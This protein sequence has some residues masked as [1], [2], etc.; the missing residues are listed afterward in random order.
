V[1][2]AID[3]WRAAHPAIPA[4]QEAQFR[5]AKRTRYV[6]VPVMGT[7]HYFMGEV[8]PTICM[9]FPIQ[10]F[11]AWIMKQ[12][13]RAV[14]AAIDW[15]ET[16][17]IAQVHDALYLETS[18]PAA[19]WDLL[20]TEMSKPVMLDGRLLAM[21]GDV[22]VGTTLG[23]LKKCKTAESVLAY[24]DHERRALGVGLGA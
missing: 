21:V 5:E 12:I 13:L 15:R 10:G 4:W 9:N 2:E 24:L 11:G 20:K 22:G 18:A 1:R 3:I 6:E 7:R 23:N 17:L 19:A 16:V 8:E 14:A